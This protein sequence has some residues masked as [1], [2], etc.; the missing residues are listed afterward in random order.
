MQNSAIGELPPLPRQFYNRDT[1]QVAMDLP[2]KVLV[3]EGEEGLSAGLIVET[4]A[5]LADD[6][7][8]HA[9]RGITARNKEMFGPPGIAYVY[10]IYGVHYCFNT[11]TREQG[12]GEAV[13]LRALK[14]LA[15]L[16]LMR[17]RRGHGVKEN[18]LCAGPGNLC[19]ALG[20][21][22]DHNGVPLWK[23]PLYITEP[24][25]PEPGRRAMV[26]TTR[27]GISKAQELLLR[28]Y[29]EDYAEYVAVK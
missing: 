23:A 7:A 20:I 10:L 29:L 21:N 25:P 9:S 18:R 22:K 4:E 11:V 16:E 26:T 8:C 17:I 15:G 5:Y 2:G 14:P 1:R 28:F 27:V 19:R 13:L 24:S 3:H 12:T 6:P